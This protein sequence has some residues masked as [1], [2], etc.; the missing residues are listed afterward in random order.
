MTPLR[1]RFY[2]DM[3]LHGL[4][5]RAQE[6]YVPIPSSGERRLPALDEGGG[7]EGGVPVDALAAQP[8]VP[9]VNGVALA[10]ELPGAPTNR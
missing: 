5:A 10:H 7:R 9:E 1:K 3:Q 4:A 2:E 8:L 6:S